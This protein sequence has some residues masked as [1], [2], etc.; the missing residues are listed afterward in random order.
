[1]AAAAALEYR[2]KLSSDL[3]RERDREH[4]IVVSSLDDDL[5]AV[6]PNAIA[7]F[8]LRANVARKI[9]TKSGADGARQNSASVAGA[10]G[11]SY[12]RCGR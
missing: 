8:R 12:G 7:A 2:S 5:C 10:T 11:G 1:V 6:A 3:L 4:A 9:E